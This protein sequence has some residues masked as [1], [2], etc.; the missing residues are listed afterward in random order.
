MKKEKKE[1]FLLYKDT[2]LVFCSRDPDKKKI[3]TVS[4]VDSGFNVDNTFLKMHCIHEF[5]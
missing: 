3:L 5:S 1:Q 2:D 4:L